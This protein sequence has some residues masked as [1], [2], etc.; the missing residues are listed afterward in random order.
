MLE[1]RSQRKKVVSVKTTALEEL[2]TSI[3]DQY[4]ADV[5]RR[6]SE[7]IEK[8]RDM[9][10]HQFDAQYTPEILTFTFSG[11]TPSQKIHT[12]KYTYEFILGAN[13]IEIYLTI[14]TSANIGIKFALKVESKQVK[15]YVKSYLKSLK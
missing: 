14:E 8:G 5:R 7:W 11:P 6:E 1:F 13:A 2:S 3:Y 10:Q 9:S 4:T 15:K 12:H